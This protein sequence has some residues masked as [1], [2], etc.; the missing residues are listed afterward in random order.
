MFSLSWLTAPA[1]ASAATTPTTTSAPRF[2]TAPPPMPA[3]G[4]AGWRFVGQGP[5]Q[6]I[7]AGTPARCP[8]Q[9]R[10]WDGVAGFRV[11]VTLFDCQTA[12]DAAVALWSLTVQAVNHAHYTQTE[13]PDH[14]LLLVCAQSRSGPCSLDALARGR[15]LIVVGAAAPPGSTLNE[16]DVVE[17][18]AA[19]QAR[20]TPGPNTDIVSQWRA[21]S[22]KRV[23]QTL[24]ALLVAYLTVIGPWAMATRPLRGERYGVRAGDSRWI[25]VTRP[26]SRL[27]HWVRLRATARALFL[28]LAAATAAPGS[29]SIG[30]VLGLLVL[31]ILG[32][33]RPLGRIGGWR[34]ARVRGLRVFASRSAWISLV[35]GIVSVGLLAAAVLAVLVPVAA[36]ASGISQSPLFVDGSLDLRYVNV[37]GLNP[38]LRLFVFTLTLPPQYALEIALATA[39]GLVAA[40]TLLRRAGRRFALPSKLHLPPPYVLY[41]RNFSDDKLKMSPSAIGR[42]SLVERLN[43][44]AR[45]P[46]EEILARHLNRLAPV[47]TAKPPGSRLPT[48]GAA[49]LTLPTGKDGEAW[50][51]VVERYA[52]AA[53][54]VVVAATPEAVQPGLLWELAL[55]DRDRAIGPVLLVLGPHPLRD[56]VT[57]WSLFVAAARVYPRFRALDSYRDDGHSGAIVM[58]LDPAVGWVT[59]GAGARTEWTYAAALSSAIDYARALGPA[60]GRIAPAA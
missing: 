19:A 30:S 49:R 13:L 40:A 16:V 36:L 42:T 4:P 10:R 29:I 37:A 38:V 32:W 11:T 56:L 24:A 35:L 22:S 12:Q 59:W 51:E 57:R 55:L 53:S 18:T 33:I 54:A 28:L 3:A 50:K 39:V 6:T 8:S 48:I 17:R 21:I 45:Q 1:E 2:I 14:S 5:G 41:L 46:F 58:V 43:P 9:L 44:F 20:L 34:P 25:D 7:L 23:N 52:V 31:A 15:L 26:A 27:K 60:S 47:V